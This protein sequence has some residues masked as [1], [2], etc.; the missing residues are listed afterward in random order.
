MKCMAL[1]TGLVLV[2]LCIKILLTLLF[3]SEVPEI[4]QTT[5]RKPV[6]KPTKVDGL[7]I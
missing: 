6:F 3:N 7:A 4:H 1:L 2:H 5:F